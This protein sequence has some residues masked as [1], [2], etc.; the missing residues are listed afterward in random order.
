[1]TIDSELITNV[2][3][4]QILIS[5]EPLDADGGIN[6]TKKFGYNLGFR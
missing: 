5:V 2:L 6:R 3:T 4:L 1:M